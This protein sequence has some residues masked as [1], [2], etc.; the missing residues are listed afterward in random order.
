MNRTIINM[1]VLST[2]HLSWRA[3]QML[4]E[5]E[6]IAAD[7]VNYG[8]LCYAHDEFV[9]EVPQEYQALCAFANRNG[10]S[11][12]KFDCD[13]EPI[14]DLP[15]FPWLDQMPLDIGTRI[16]TLEGECDEGDE[17]ERHAP[18]GSIGTVISRRHAPD[19][20]AGEKW[21]HDVI[22]GPSGVQVILFESELV[23]PDKYQ[24]VND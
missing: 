3:K 6:K 8:W 17:G 24:I 19:G 20:A 23:D 9:D 15:T 16:K 21:H 4:E 22:F 10:C 18:S 1:L 12:I 11:W 14:K 5:G 2:A 13:A 7:K